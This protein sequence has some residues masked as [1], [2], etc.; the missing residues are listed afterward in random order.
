M[1][2]GHKRFVHFDNNVYSLPLWCTVQRIRWLKFSLEKPH[3]HLIFISRITEIYW[4]GTREADT[5]HWRTMRTCACRT[6]T[7]GN[8]LSY[9]PL[10]SNN[11]SARFTMW[12]FPVSCVSFIFFPAPLTWFCCFLLSIRNVPKRKIKILCLC[13]RSHTLPIT[14]MELSTKSAIKWNY[15]RAAYNARL[16]GTQFICKQMVTCVLCYGDVIEVHK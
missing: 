5:Y 1:N 2:Y 9:S 15:D 7:V 4:Q 8:C 16:N 3:T 11:S 12:L 10:K 13:W 14:L 6:V